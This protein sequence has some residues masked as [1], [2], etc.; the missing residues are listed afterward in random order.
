[1]F[2]FSVNIKQSQKK[3]KEVVGKQAVEEHYTT[4]GCFNKKTKTRTVWKDKIEQVEYQKLELPDT[5]NMAR[6]WSAGI[7]DEKEKLWD[8]LRDWMINHLKEVDYE[9]EQSIKDT[10]NF[11]NRSLQ[12]QLEIIQRDFE[13]EV[14]RWDEITLG[15]DSVLEIRQN[16]ENE[17]RTS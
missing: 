10:I 2:N 4:G 7:A 14:K 9:F 17:S 3:N 16:L 13:A 11:V 6:Q 12:E 1:M 5:D 15:K 8:I